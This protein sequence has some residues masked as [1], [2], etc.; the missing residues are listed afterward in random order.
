MVSG[1]GRNLPARKIKR[2][3]KTKGWTPQIRGGGNLDDDACFYLIGIRPRFQDIAKLEE[4]VSPDFV[5]TFFIQ[6]WI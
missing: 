4:K 2:A 1:R 5:G 6:H 3:T